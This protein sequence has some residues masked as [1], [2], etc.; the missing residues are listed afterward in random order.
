MK[1]IAFWNLENGEVMGIVTI[2]DD[3]EVTCDNEQLSLRM[4]LGLTAEEVL[5]RYSSRSNGYNFQSKLIADG[6]TPEPL[7]LIEGGEYI[8]TK[9]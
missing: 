8:A 2:S 6:V 7:P 5:S 4:I 1:R 3:G 9:K